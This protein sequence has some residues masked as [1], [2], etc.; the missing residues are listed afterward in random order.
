MGAKAL[1]ASAHRC[2]ARKPRHRTAA[3]TSS[4][5]LRVIRRNRH[6]RGLQCHHWKHCTLWGHCLHW[7]HWILCAHCTH[8]DVIGK[9]N[10]PQTVTAVYRGLRLAVFDLHG[11][12]GIDA[13]PHLLHPR[14]QI[15]DRLPLSPSTGSSIPLAPSTAPPAKA[16]AY[17]QADRSSRHPYRHDVRTSARPWRPPSVRQ[18]S[19]R[20]LQSSSRASQLRPCHADQQTVSHDV[21]RAHR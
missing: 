16:P 13:S 10:K 7:R 8:R 3:R 20:R 4:G 17:R 6:P 1:S 2:N 21:I 18:R 15:R 19:D 14:S 9:R 11:P 5:K 12:T